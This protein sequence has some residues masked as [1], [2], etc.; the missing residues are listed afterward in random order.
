MEEL[1]II[2]G[3]FDPFALQ[4]ATLAACGIFSAACDQA[5]SLSSY[6]DKIGGGFHIQTDVIGIPRGSGLGTSSI[7]AGACVKAIYE[8]F[9]M[10]LDRDD[11]FRRVLY[12]EQLM[13]TG[14]GWQDQIGGLIPGIKF[15]STEPGPQSHFNITNIRISAQTLAELEERFVLIDSGQRRLARNLLREIMG[16]YILSEPDSVNALSEIQRIATQMRTELEQGNVDGFITLLDK[17]WELSK[18]LDPNSTNTCIEEVF[19]SCG[20]LMAGKMIC[21]AGGGGFLQGFLKKGVTRDQLSK[22]LENVFGNSGVNVR[23]CIFVME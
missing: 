8:F 22:Q 1:Q 5:R 7:L 2:D 15:I 21:G 16:K 13:H 23:E 11:L 19:S 12:I 17:H 18:Q 6:L 10:T 20:D 4:K 14:G 3:P 9:G